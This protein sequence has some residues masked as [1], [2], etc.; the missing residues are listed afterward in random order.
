MCRVWAIGIAA[1]LTEVY[2]D[3]EHRTQHW[4]QLVAIANSSSANNA[5]IAR[6]EK[7]VEEFNTI[8][9]RSRSPRMRPRQRALPQSQKVLALPALPGASSQVPQSKGRGGQ[10]NRKREGGR[11]KGGAGGKGAGKGMSLEKM[12]D[13]GSKKVFPLF[14]ARRTTAWWRSGTSWGMAWDP[15]NVTRCR[16]K[17]GFHNR[18]I[19]WDTPMARWAAEGNDWIKLL[20][21]QP[22]K[23]KTLEPPSFEFKLPMKNTRRLYPETVDDI[24]SVS[25]G[26]MSP[27]L[28]DMWR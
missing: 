4:I 21:E 24:D 12:M 16:H 28:G 2:R 11:G 18:G 27:D 20:A 19:Q 10:N 22:R 15:T 9:Q 26:S 23:K 13:L 6:L 8:V 17:V 14:H 7:E 1:A 3:N 5:T 25:S